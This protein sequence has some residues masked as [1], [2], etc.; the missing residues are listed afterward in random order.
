MGAQLGFRTVTVLLMGELTAACSLP[1]LPE[2][3]N[4]HRGY[5]WRKRPRVNPSRF[6]S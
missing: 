2:F 4:A 5:G 6:P 1:K 3:G